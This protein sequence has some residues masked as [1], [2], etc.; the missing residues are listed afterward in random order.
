MRPGL[1]E[2]LGKGGRGLGGD[3][4]SVVA[5]VR[6]T[7]ELS[8]AR[9]ASGLAGEEVLG[10][11]GVSELLAHRAGQEQ[12]RTAWPVVRGDVLGLAGGV[13]QGSREFPR[14]DHGNSSPGARPV[15]AGRS[16]AMASRWRRMR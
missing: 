13:C 15:R 2:H 11:G 8:V 3:A 12:H 6:C 9:F 16:A 1:S 10:I 4:Q 7:S 14:C 5:I